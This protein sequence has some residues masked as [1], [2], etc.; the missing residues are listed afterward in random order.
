MNSVVL[1]N[2]TNKKTIFKTKNK[3]MKTTIATIAAAVLMTLSLSS[4]ASTSNSPLKLKGA[5]EILLT[6]TEATTIGTTDMNNHL[7]TNDFQ[8]E[9][10]ANNNKADKKAY[11]K[12][13]KQN[14]GL[15]FDC[16][17]KTEILDQTGNTAIAKTSYAFK[18]FTRVDHIILTQTTEGWKISKVTSSYLPVAL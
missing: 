17:T 13:L 5:T 2:H 4:F 12:F 18:D 8:Y 11:L 9:N 3:D 16:K 14:E 10:L 6:Y 1:L 7:F 15:T